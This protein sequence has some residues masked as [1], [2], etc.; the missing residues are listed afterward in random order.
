[1][2]VILRLLV[3]GVDDGYFPLS[4][5]KGLG[6]APLISVTF[7]GRFIIDVDFDFITVD[8]EDGT[9]VFRS[10][11]RGDI[12]IIDNVICGGFNYI[13]PTTNYIFFFGK[14]PNTQLI[15][16]T[17][18]KNFRDDERRIRTIESILKNLIYLPTKKG[19]VYVNTDLELQTVKDVIENYQIFVKYPEPI[20]AAH[21][22]GRAIGQLHVNEL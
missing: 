1:M 11:R 5:K 8:G 4:Y 17:L 14:K 18:R 19:T 6:K 2:R 20:R 21:I 15:L 10:L 16:E 9:R 22:V 7:N 3:S 12:T 13:E